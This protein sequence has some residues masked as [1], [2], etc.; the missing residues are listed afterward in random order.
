MAKKISLKDRLAFAVDVPSSE[1][2]ALVAKLAGKVGW[3]KFNSA[4]IGQGKAIIDQAWKAGTKTFFD[5]K[6]KDIPNTLENYVK[7]LVDMQGARMFNVHADGGRKMMTK[8]A[9]TIH[10]LFPDENCPLVIAV[11]VLTSFDQAEFTEA[12]YAGT[13]PEQVL[14]LAKLAK[15]CGC[16]GVVASPQEA[17]MLKREVGDDFL[18]VT[19]GIRF[20]E[21]ATDDQARLATPKAA[22]I[23]GSDILVMGRSLIKGGEAAVRR[24]YQEIETGLANRK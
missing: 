15:D 1:A 2:P 13:I 21:E 12:G 5:P 20:E 24:A 23:A 14:R 4:F 9:E 3:M 10:N 16:D 18:V 8:V 11:T 7:E 17:A 22:I 19:P 6:W